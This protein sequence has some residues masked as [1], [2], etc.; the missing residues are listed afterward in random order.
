MRRL[1]EMLVC[2]TV[3][4]VICLTLTGRSIDAGTPPPCVDGDIDGDGSLNVTDAIYL[5][6][7]LFNSGP[8]PVAC[9]SGNELTP[10]S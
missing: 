10:E 6:T 4:A 5:P 9:A 7:H 2:C 8:P 3:V 1:V